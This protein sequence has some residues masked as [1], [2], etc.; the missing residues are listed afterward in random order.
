MVTDNAKAAKIK[1]SAGRAKGTGQ[2][3]LQ[4]NLTLDSVDEVLRA[5]REAL[6]KYDTLEVRVERV[7][8]ID[9]GFLQLLHAL[10]RAYREHGG[11]LTVEMNLEKDLEM[12]LRNTGFVSWLAPQPAKEK[13]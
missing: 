4:G 12:L 8:G 1:L 2:V 3:V 9:L 5:F 11:E 10:E 13:K 7:S 6:Q